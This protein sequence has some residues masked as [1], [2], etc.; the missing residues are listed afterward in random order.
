MTYSKPKRKL[1]QPFLQLLSEANRICSKLK[2]YN[3]II[4]IPYQVDL[5]FHSGFSNTLKP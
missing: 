4:K 1:L 2:A 3:K 5:A